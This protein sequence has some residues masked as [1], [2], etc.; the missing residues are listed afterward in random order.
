MLVT[1]K[2]ILDRASEN[3]YAVAAPN[4][5]NELN[6]RACIEAAEEMHAPLILDV[7]YRAVGDLYFFGHLLRALAQQSCVP[8]AIN[9]DHGDSL[10]QV[11]RAIQAGFTSVMIDR[12]AC[13]DAVNIQEVREIVQLAHAAGISVEAELG[14]VGHGGQTDSSLSWLTDPAGVKEYIEKTQVDCLAVAI[15][16]AHGAYPENYVP[17]L[18]LDRLVQIKKAAGNFPLVLHGSSGTDEVSLRKACQLG[19][20]KVNINHDLCKA[21]A[22]A[23]KK[24]SFEGNRAYMI[25]RVAK[26]GF[27]QKLKA[28][29]EVYGSQNQAWQPTRS[30]LPQAQFP[31]K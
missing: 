5:D 22:E 13:P 7:A 11:Q 17:K 15:G 27:K 9:L 4:V 24:E 26:A 19:I 10:E 8:I 31:L 21:A 16:T 12:S 23:V 28:M 20:N 1:M 29:I 2:E 14:H 25:F 3:G 18:D 30:G 6:A